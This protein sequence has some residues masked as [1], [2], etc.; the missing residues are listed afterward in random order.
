MLR[1]GKERSEI[2]VVYDQVGSPTAAAD[3]AA[4]ILYLIQQ[5]HNI[6]TGVYHY[7]NKGV[8]SWYDFACDVMQIAGYECVV[9]PIYTKDYPTPATRPA[10]SV[11]ATEKICNDF[12]VR[13]PH[14]RSSLLKV[15]AQLIKK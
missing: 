12:G 11:L 8:A 9:N 14:W 3:L 10:Y 2:G 1:I 15:M 7:A 5:P 13:I 4:A 6:R